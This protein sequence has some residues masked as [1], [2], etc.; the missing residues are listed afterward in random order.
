MD[1][2][3]PVNSRWWNGSQRMLWSSSDEASKRTLTWWVLCI[4]STAQCIADRS[5]SALD[6]MKEYERLL[7]KMVL[8]SS[9]RRIQEAPL[10]WLESTHDE[11]T[12]HF[13]HPDGG[14]IHPIGCSVLN[15]SSTTSVFVLRIMVFCHEDASSKALYAM[16]KAV[17]TLFS[18]AKAFLAFYSSHTIHGNTL[19]VLE[20]PSFELYTFKRCKKFRK[21]KF[22]ENPIWGNGMLARSQTSFAF[23]HTKIMWQMLSDSRSQLEHVVSIWIPLVDKSSLTAKAPD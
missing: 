8:P 9:P 23:S 14:L 15:S 10:G 20:S 21:T 2:T 12:L 1:C 7:C 18:K 3:T 13:K 17:T 16:M 5:A 19:H 4:H 22:L 6:R 11:P